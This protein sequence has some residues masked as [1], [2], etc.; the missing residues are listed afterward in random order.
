VWLGIDDTDSRRGGCTTWALTELVGV[1][2]VHG[3]DLLGEPR[4]VRLN[5]NV[6]WKTRG[7][8]ALAM[9]LGRGRGTAETV[10]ELGGRAVL[11][12][13]RGT[14]ATVD[15]A[16]GFLAAAWHRLLRIAP[17]ERG[18]D[19][20]MVAVD[21]ALPTAL[22]RDAVRDVVRVGPVEERLRRAGAV[23][24]VRGGRR[25]II[26]AAAA[27]AWP[28]SRSTWELLA[29]RRPER[30]GLPREVVAST[31]VD[32]Q[33]RESELFLC[34]DP[35]TR[36]LLVAPHTDCPILFGLR[37]T[38]PHA[39][40]A[41]RPTIA[42]EPTDRWMLFRTNQATGD[43]LV[44]RRAAELRA[45]LSAIVRGTVLGDPVSLRGGHVRFRV[46]DSV[47]DR[48]NCLA[49]EP[50]KTLPAA[51][52]Q[53]RNGDSVRVWGAF[54]GRRTLRL[55]GLEVVRLSRG[56]RRLPPV[57]PRCRRTTASLGAGRGWRCPGCRA[58][59]PPEAA[60]SVPVLRTLA[61]GTVHPTP[62]A[63]RHLA[64]LP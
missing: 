23:V 36:R 15:G 20:A 38:S 9:R 25:G 7:N 59:S 32:A 14:P 4:L 53:L 45:Y 31:V 5:P 19:P 2:R 57:C 60:R 21:E 13:E 29:Y 47:G 51:A 3:L 17:E 6:P 52:R 12:Y 28:G 44:P 61:R 40:K 55:E 41:A 24:R 16:A 27:I 56:L 35:R 33:R 10:G 46:R 8:A 42:A 30:V 18:T 54:G 62:S 48:L 43:H 34:H 37:A 58:R 26:G 22:Y 1:A 50:T 39:P 11:A 64:P 49:F 63:R